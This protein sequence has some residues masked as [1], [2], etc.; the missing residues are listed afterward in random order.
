MSTLKQLV[1]EA[2]RGNKSVVTIPHVKWMESS[3]ED[4][5]PSD[6]AVEHALNV[7]R[8]GY[9]HERA[10]RFS[11]SAIGECHRRVCFG[12]AGAPQLKPAFENQE[13]MDHGSWIHLKWQVE[14]LTVGYMTS[15]EEWVYDKDLL[16]GGSM[17]A[18]LSD[19]SIFELKSAGWSI[20][21]RIVV[22]D[23]WP[24]WENLMQLG[25]YFLLADIDMA[26]LVMED[27]SSGKFHEFR[28]PRDAKIEEEVLRRLRSYKSYVEADELPEM[29]DECRTK[30]G[31]T[32]KRCGYREICEAACSV[33]QFGKVK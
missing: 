9:K 4:K 29:L 11:P 13:M 7:W 5:R 31:T 14:G 25:T 21:N 23:G 18:V 22:V 27:R 15:A 24:K 30:R 32:Y 10:G 33:S 17:D 19:G 6:V 1:R 16:C 28:I 20:Y 3:E 8:G 26:S 2:G 12:F